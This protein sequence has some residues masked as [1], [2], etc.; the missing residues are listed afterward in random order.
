MAGIDPN[1]FQ[2]LV[3]SSSRPPGALVFVGDFSQFVFFCCLSGAGRARTSCAGV[4]LAV[5]DFEVPQAVC[6]WGGLR[7]EGGFVPTLEC[8]GRFAECP[9]G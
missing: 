5:P 3:L 6:L 9:R 4:P 7:L 1:R 2:M 8:E